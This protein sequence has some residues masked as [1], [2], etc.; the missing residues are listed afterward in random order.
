[1]EELKKRSSSWIKDQGKE[2][3]RFLW[4]DGY[5]GFSIGASQ[6]THVKSYLAKQ[7]IHHRKVTFQEELVEFLKKYEIPYDEKYLWK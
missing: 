2:F 4:Q 5:G 7:K 6:V 1:M 3:S